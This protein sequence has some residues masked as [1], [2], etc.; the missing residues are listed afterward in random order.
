MKNI[1]RLI[2][3]TL[4]YLAFG[5][6]AFA[7][8]TV[9]AY[10]EATIIAPIGIT[11]EVDMNFG[12]VSVINSAGTVVLSTASVRSSTGGA[13]PVAN[14]TGV[15]T[16]A[17]FTVS[18]DAGYHIFVTLPASCIITHT[19]GTNTMTVNAFVC[20]PPTNFIM[21]IGGT[22]TL[23]VGATLITGANQLPGVYHS[24]NDFNVTVNYN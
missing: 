18:G 12:N 23:L 5:T 6:S 11:K 16:A 4:V 22:Q 14:P 1:I 17:S 13:T 24:L 15:V 2:G 8:A 9:G 19:N 10:A 21:P 7:Q 3:I 20:D